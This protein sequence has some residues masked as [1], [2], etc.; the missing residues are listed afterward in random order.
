MFSHGIWIIFGKEVIRFSNKLDG[1]VSDFVLDSFRLIVSVI[2]FL[3]RLAR[4]CVMGHSMTE[5]I[6]DSVVFWKD[7]M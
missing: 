7:I 6:I 5:S 3:D 2:Y 4:V 1:N